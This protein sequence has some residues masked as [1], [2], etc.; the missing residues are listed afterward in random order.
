MTIKIYRAFRSSTITV[1]F[2]AM[3]ALLEKTVRLHPP[4]D[5]ARFNVTHISATNALSDK[6]VTFQ[7]R[8]ELFPY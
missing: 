8:R 5:E 1:R 2:T 3:R 4:H 6:W 7:P